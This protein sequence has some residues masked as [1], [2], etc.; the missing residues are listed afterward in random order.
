MEIDPQKRHNGIRIFSSNTLKVIACISMLTDHIG[1]VFMEN[2]IG[3][4]A[5]GRLAFPIFAFLVVQ[6]LMHT[7]DVRKYLLRMGTFALI[8]E[9]PFDLALHDRMWYPQAQNIFFTLTAGLLAIY[10]MESSERLGRWRVEIT[11]ASA[12]IAEFLRFDYGMAGVGIIFIFYWCEKGRQAG[13]LT[14]SG[15][16]GKLTYFSLRQNMEAFIMSAITYVL[17]LGMGQMYAL[18][19]LI[20]INMYSGKRGIGNIKYLFYLFYPVHLLVKWLVWKNNC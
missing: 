13:L 3:M 11:F 8:S 16:V 17:C 2:D 18:L 9:I 7:S 4:R 10:S 19:A 14:D 6:G 20:P 15:D 12:L 1:L 5:V